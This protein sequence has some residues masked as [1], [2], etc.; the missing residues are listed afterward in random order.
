MKSV[1]GAGR[2]LPQSGN[3]W[4]Q[5]GANGPGNFSSDSPRPWPNSPPSAC[6]NSDCWIEPDVEALLDVADRLREEEGAEAEDQQAGDH[7]GEARGGDVEHRQEGAEE[8]QRAAEVA[9]EDQ[10]HHRRAPDH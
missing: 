2:M 8:H 3:G 10:Q 1:C 4:A 6:A 7:I 5:S 9:D